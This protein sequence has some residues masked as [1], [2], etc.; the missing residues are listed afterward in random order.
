MCLF[1]SRL[2]LAMTVLEQELRYKRWKDTHPY[3]LGLIWLKVSWF[4]LVLGWEAASW[5]FHKCIMRLS[6]CCRTGLKKQSVSNFCFLDREMT[7]QI[8]GQRRSELFA[9]LWIAWCAVLWRVWTAVFLGTVWA[10]LPMLLSFIHRQGDPWTLNC[11]QFHFLCV[12]DLCLGKTTVYLIPSNYLLEK[13]NICCWIVGGSHI[14]KMVIKVW[15]AQPYK[16]F[17]ISLKSMEGKM[18]GFVWSCISSLQQR[19]LTDVYFLFGDSWQWMNF[20]GHASFSS[21][22]FGYTSPICFQVANLLALDC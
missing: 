22:S 1:K 3:A 8:W 6:W 14:W 20:S 13:H 9:L 16:T 5:S 4:S 19:K 12:I 15:D 10:E 2:M 18:F 21:W 11:S 17:C 7:M